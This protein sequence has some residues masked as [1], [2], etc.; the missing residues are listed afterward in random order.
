MMQKK[1]DTSATEYHIAWASLSALAEPLFEIDWK[2]KFPMLKKED[3]CRMTEDQAAS[4]SISEGQR[5]VSISWIW[6]QHYGTREEEL[7]DAM[8]IE[9]CKAH[10][11]ANQW[12]EE[13]ELLQEEMHHVLAFFD[14]HVAWWV[15]CAT[16]KTW[17]RPIENEG[18]VA[19]AHWQ[20]AIQRMM[21][22]HCSSIWSV[23]PGLMA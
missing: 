20:A 21:H 19:Y 11:H 8:C 7:S 17:L 18:A 9:W 15:E 10:A 16:S 3:V 23:I 22:D 12:S 14:W 5:L 4:E 13:V 2:T 1:I 6:K